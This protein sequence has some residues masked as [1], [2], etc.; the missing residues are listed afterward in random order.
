MIKQNKFTNVKIQTETKIEL[1]K[2]KGNKESYN[3]LFIRLMKENQKL[4]KILLNIEDLKDYIQQKE[5][6]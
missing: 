1:D 5:T 3:D 4:N 2:I 6:I